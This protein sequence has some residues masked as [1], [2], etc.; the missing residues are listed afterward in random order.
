[1]D[2]SNV[3]NSYVA[4]LYNI[5]LAVQAICQQQLSKKQNFYY[6]IVADSQNVLQLFKLPKY[7]NRQ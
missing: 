2:N 5:Y 4:K 1:M 6:V 3:L 7:Q